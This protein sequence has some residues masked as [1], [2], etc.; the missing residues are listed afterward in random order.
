M[1][2]QIQT[3]ILFDAFYFEEIEDYQ[4]LIPKRVLIGEADDKRIKFYDKLSQQV[5]YN[6]DYAIANGMPESFY[7]V[8]DLKD[9]EEKYNTEEFATLAQL[10]L[11][12]IRKNVYYFDDITSQVMSCEDVGKFYD[13]SGIKIVYGFVKDDNHKFDEDNSNYTELGAMTEAQMPSIQ[14]AYDEITKHILCQDQQVKKLLTAIYKNIY[15]N[16]E[17][18]KSNVL[19]YGPTGVGK[20]AMLKKIA[21]IVNLPL[22]IEDSTRFTVSGYKGSDVED[23]LVNLYYAANGDLELAERGILVFD[24]IDKKSASDDVSTITTEGPLNGMLKIVE[25]SIINVEVSPNETIPFDTSKLTV[26]FSGAFSKMENKLGLDKKPLGFST[27]EVKKAIGGGK[28]SYTAED[29]I[30]YG[31]NPEFIG[32]INCFIPLNSLSLE[33]IK[34]ILRN[35]DSSPLKAYENTFK[36]LGI[37]ILTQEKLITL[38]AEKAY[39]MNTGA[40][41]LKVIVNE[42]FESILFDLF[43]DNIKADKIKLNEEILEDNTKGYQF[44]KKAPKRYKVVPKKEQI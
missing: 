27:G 1:E 31:F 16:N 38:I 23:A 29:F 14:E 42:M 3:A 20:T 39:K 7:Y 40:R 2:K 28:R 19:L 13:K 34:N 30:K 15:F 21:K 37:D 22:V 35:S 32:R 4:F 9:L 36:E 44:I 33:D 24:E 8:N 18:M 11:E 41:S 12:D 43:S 10:Y 6:C 26:I 5:Y 25:G 17:E